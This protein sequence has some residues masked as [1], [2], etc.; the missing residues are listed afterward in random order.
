MVSGQGCRSGQDCRSGQGLVSGQALVSGCAPLSAFGGFPSTLGLASSGRLDEAEESLRLYARDT[1][2]PGGES[3]ASTIIGGLRD[4]SRRD[5]AVSAALGWLDYGDTQSYWILDWLVLM[6]ARE[7]ALDVV[8]GMFETSPHELS[9]I[10][11]SIATH[12]LRGEPRFDAAVAALN[13][14][15][16][17]PAAE[18]IPW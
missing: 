2:V 13:I 15:D 7:E 17:P 6:G 9:A 8:E 16:P 4:P 10:N 12:A 3:E 14:P 1:G 5:E 11:A 18:A